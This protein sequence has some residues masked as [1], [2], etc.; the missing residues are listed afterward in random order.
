VKTVH[1]AI[2]DVSGTIP[3]FVNGELSGAGFVS[4][5]SEFDI[6]S[7]KWN[8]IAVKAVTLDE[9]LKDR[10]PDFIKID[11]EGFEYR[12]ILGARDILRRRHCVFLIEV[13]PW[14]DPT[15]NK[16]PGDIF[17]LF[18]RNGYGFRRY[19]RHWIFEPTENR[20]FAF[21]RTQAIK[22]IYRVA[23]IRK[24]AKY[25][26]LAFDRAVGRTSSR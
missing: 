8:E 17:E 4:K 16:K 24:T 6:P 18:Y 11:I 3:F 10:D 13:H 14:G 26:A 9:L 2:S 25:L 15:I 20:L 12:A 22:I 19:H 21:A 5:G 7:L 1:A 23:P